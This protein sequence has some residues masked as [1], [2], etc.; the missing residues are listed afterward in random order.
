MKD[1]DRAPGGPGT[2]LVLKLGR[3]ERIL[4]NGAL[5]VNDR[6]TEIRV[7]TKDAVVL[8]G[9]LQPAPETAED[10]RGYRARTY[11]RRRQL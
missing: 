6:E 8:R 10:G 1:A 4:V 5:I 11:R 9:G 2:G 7:L 3:N